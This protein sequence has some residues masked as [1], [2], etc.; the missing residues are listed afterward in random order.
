[1]LKQLRVVR[2]VFGGGIL[3]VALLHLVEINPVLMEE[4]CLWRGE[5]I[6]ENSH[7]SQSQ[8]HPAVPG[9]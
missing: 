6:K 7:E 3:S 5:D 2:S 9:V 1:M 8:S 4:S